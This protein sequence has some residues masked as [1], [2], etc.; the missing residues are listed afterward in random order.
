MNK[1]AIKV[2]SGTLIALAC[3][4]TATYIGL[5][6]LNK[7]QKPTIQ[8]SPESWFTWNGNEITGLTKLGE[9]ETNIILPAKTTLI[10]NDVFNNNDTIKSVDMSL[11]KISTI[12]DGIIDIDNNNPGDSNFIGLFQNCG[13]LT[14]V[15]L[16][17]GL[18]YIGVG[19]F[20]FCEYLTTIN[21]PDS[22]TSIGNYSFAGCWALTSIEIPDSVTSIG[23]NAFNGAAL[24]KIKLPSGLTSI[25]EK[26]FF[27]L[28]L[29]SI[30]IPDSVTLI[31]ESA[32]DGCS[33]LT[34]INIPD[35]VTVIA[36][37][38]FLNCT[39]LSSIKLSDQLTNIG[40]KAFA[41]TALTSI[42]IP[43]SVVSIGEGAFDGISEVNAPSSIVELVK[44]S[45][46]TGK[47]NSVSLL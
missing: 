41:E 27:G 40:A 21:I 42:T 10:A 29:T 7:T 44:Q 18:T 22:V 8:A 37:N 38:A 30:E 5:S 17:Y 3:I 13:Y 14:S 1:K 9:Q 36:D 33:S 6:T 20:C 24:T 26:T 25:E 2:I 15:I 39:N 45:G 32:F 19:A 11:T 46:Y 28:S 43:N 31:G 4:G 47:I 16:P 34:S 35:S 12:P 23:N